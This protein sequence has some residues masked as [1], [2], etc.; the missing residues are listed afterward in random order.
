MAKTLEDI[1]GKTEGKKSGIWDFLVSAY[2]SSKAIKIAL[3][4]ATAGYSA[5]FVASASALFYFGAKTLGAGIKYATRL[6][7][8]PSEY[9][10]FK[11]IKTTIY[12]TLELYNPFGKYKRP[13][14]MG[15]TLSTI[16]HITGF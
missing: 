1:V 16:T 3:L 5:Y 11:G 10:S 15:A 2:S 7:T 8:N 4:T 9:L 6:V 12:E 13:T 14:F